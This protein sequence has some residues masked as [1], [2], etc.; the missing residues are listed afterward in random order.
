MR[1]EVCQAEASACAKVL[2]WEGGKCGWSRGRKKARVTGNG[3][4]E[5]AGYRVTL[6]LDNQ[7]K[8]PIFYLKRDGEPKEGFENDVM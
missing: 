8:E 2:G 1:G 3:A 4:L 6:V 7:Q 5:L